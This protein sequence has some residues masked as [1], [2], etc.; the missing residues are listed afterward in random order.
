MKSAEPWYAEDLR[1]ECGRCGLCCRGAGNVCVSDAEISSLAQALEVSDAELR[2]LYTRRAGRRGVVLRQKRNQDCVFW[3][4]KSGC[5]V[6]AQRPRQCRTYPFWRGLVHSS[7]SWE[8]EAS[9]CPG[10]GR[11]SLH[12]AEVIEARAADDGIPEH[13]TRL[14]TS[15]T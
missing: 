5:Q 15:R 6:Y 8:S 2:S 1:F 7:E 14:G 3:H 9:S 4:S 11:G 13:R 12:A 10:I